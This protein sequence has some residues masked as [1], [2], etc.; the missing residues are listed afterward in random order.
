ST[1]ATSL[2]FKTTKAS[3]PILVNYNAECGVLG[4]AGQMM[5]CAVVPDRRAGCAGRCFGRRRHRQTDTPGAA[6]WV[7]GLI[8]RLGMCGIFAIAVR[9]QAGEREFG[10]APVSVPIAY[11]RG[12]LV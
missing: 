11:P 1:G 2:T 10:I 6:G 12:V 8:F 4:P 7:R 3:T 5:R 9:T